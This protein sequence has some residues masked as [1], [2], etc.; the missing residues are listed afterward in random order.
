MKPIYKGAECCLGLKK[1]AD[2]IQWC[3]IGLNVDPDDKK[4]REIRAKA[5]SERV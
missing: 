3:E 2:C 4:L 5:E 1:Y